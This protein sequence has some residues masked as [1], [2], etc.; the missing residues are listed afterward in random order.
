MAHDMFNV[1]TPSNI[2]ELKF[3]IEKVKEVKKNFYEG[4]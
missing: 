3:F 4:E 1:L 2:T